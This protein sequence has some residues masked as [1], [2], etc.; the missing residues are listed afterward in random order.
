[1][2][3][4]AVERA[5]AKKK[6]SQVSRLNLRG[7]GHMDILDWSFFLGAHRKKS[8]VN[9]VIY[10]PEDLPVGGC[11]FHWFI[12]CEKG[13][14]IHLTRVQLESILRPSHATKRVQHDFSFCGLSSAWRGGAWTEDIDTVLIEAPPD[15]EEACSIC[16]STDG[17]AVSEI[18]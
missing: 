1:M 11:D 6:L 12:W 14:R 5:L 10:F 4:W 3:A 13:R 7:F 16:C 8:Q 18:C 15:H 9:D 17:V 2:Q